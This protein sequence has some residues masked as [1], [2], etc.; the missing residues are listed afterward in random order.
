MVNLFPNN[1]IMNVAN[2][3]IDDIRSDNRSTFVTISYTDWANGRRI[4][5]TVQLVVGRNTTI[6]D[7]SGN[8]VPVSELTP[9]MI[10]NASFSASM[11]RS[12][13]PQAN[14]FLIRIVRSATSENIITGRIVNVDRENRSF[15]TASDRN[16][17]SITRFNVPR[18]TPIYDSNGRTMNFSRLMPGMRVKVRHADFMTASI[19]PQTTAFE[20]RVL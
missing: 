18:T 15:T 8:I 13:P 6:L 19:P 9:G 7:E 1:F 10:V 16:A 17:S 20:V 12:I 11:T 14:A 4:Q 3:I 5:Q 2:A